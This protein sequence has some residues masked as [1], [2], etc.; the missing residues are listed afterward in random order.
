[1]LKAT[2]LEIWPNLTNSL[3]SLC[4]N[5]EAKP[6]SSDCSPPPF[7]PYARSWETTMRHRG[8]RCHDITIYA[9]RDILLFLLLDRKSV[10]LGKECLRLC[11]SR[12]SPYH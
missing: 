2:D 10:V 3:T 4:W 11:R 9:T 8:D 1:M 5:D 6:T 7:S 12:W